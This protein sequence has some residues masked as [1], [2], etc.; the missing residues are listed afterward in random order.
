MRKTLYSFTFF[1]VIL[2]TYKKI[3]LV[4][5]YYV[6]RYSKIKVSPLTDILCIIYYTISGQQW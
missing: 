1:S 6:T 4:G 5:I 3:K 2:Y